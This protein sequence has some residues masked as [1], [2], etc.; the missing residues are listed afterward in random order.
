[1][2]ILQQ[3]T[4]IYLKEETWHESKLSAEYSDKYFKKLLDQGNI[5]YILRQGTVLAY[6]EVWFVTKEQLAHIMEGKS[7]HGSE[8]KVEDG[9]YAYVNSIYVKPRF[10]H[11]GLVNRLHRMAHISKRKNNLIAI[12][13]KEHKHGGRFRVFNIKGEYNG[14]IKNNN[15]NTNTVNSASYANS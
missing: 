7:F 2:K 4:E 12:V 15:R 14:R 1:M 13:L 6:M 11:L 10:R 5:F 9:R 8:E 3:L